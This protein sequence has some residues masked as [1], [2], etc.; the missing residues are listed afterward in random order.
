MAGMITDQV[1]AGLMADVSAMSAT[2]HRR[3]ARA[4]WIGLITGA[5]IGAAAVV[6][7]VIYR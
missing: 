2:R 1:V 5:S 7:A 4:R 6:I 3:E